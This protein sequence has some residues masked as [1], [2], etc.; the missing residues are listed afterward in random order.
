VNRPAVYVK[1]TVESL[2]TVLPFARDNGYDLEIVD[3]IKPRVFW[4]CFDTVR[5]RYLE[6]LPGFPGTLSLHG[7]FIDL[8]LH[9]LDPKVAELSRDAWLRTLALSDELDVPFTIFHGNLVPLIDEEPYRRNWVERHVDFMGQVCQDHRSAV[10]LENLWDRAPELFAEVLDRLASPAAGMC[11]D[12]GHCTVHSPLDVEDW[13]RVLGPHVRILHVNDNDGVRDQ[14][15]PPGRG[16]TDWRRLTDLIQRHCLAPNV[17]LELSSLD[18]VRD[19]EAYMREHR[20]YP[21]V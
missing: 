21:F 5:E 9:S 6:A 2:D 18:D 19:A 17:S 15:L 12:I 8:C 11:L 13:L 10:L 7:P 20:V 4:E 1:V 14:E 16:V 3:L